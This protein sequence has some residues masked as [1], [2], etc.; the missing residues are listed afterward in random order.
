MSNDDGNVEVYDVDNSSVGENVNDRKVVADKK[1]MEEEVVLG[2]KNNVEVEN[3]NNVVAGKYNVETDHGNMDTKKKVIKIP[4]CF[5]S[6]VSPS[7]ALSPSL[8]P[9]PPYQILSPKYLYGNLTSNTNLLD[10][11]FH[12]FGCLTGLENSMSFIPEKFVKKCRAVYINQVYGP[13]DCQS[14]G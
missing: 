4:K 2:S 8:S 11:P 1:N 9:S 7:P 3:K 5:G 14:F 12:E 13:R 10:I 6:A